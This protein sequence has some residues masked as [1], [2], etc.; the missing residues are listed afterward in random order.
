MCLTERLLRFDDIQLDNPGSAARMESDAMAAIESLL[1]VINAPVEFPLVQSLIA[2]DELVSSSLPDWG[3]GE[4]QESALSGK[5]VG[6]ELLLRQ[7][8]VTTAFVYVQPGAG[9]Q[10]FPGPLP[11]GRSSE[12]TRPDVLRRFGKP[13]R[14]GGTQTLPVLGRQGGWDRF[15]VGPVCI[16]FQYNEVDERIRL[17]TL[18]VTGNAP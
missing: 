4:P 11:G 6:Y 3:E 9:F 12:S 15:E 17:V 10:A 14:S 2:A 5:T 1:A 16:H 18:M 13:S 8:R 7:G